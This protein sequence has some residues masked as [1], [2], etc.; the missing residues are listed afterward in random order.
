[1]TTDLD[2]KIRISEEAGLIFKPTLKT[3]L[4]IKAIMDLAMMEA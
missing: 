3:R 1:M 4:L 2:M